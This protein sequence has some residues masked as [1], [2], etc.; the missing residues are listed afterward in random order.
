MPRI[1]NQ[2]PTPS[3]QGLPPQSN[4]TPSER[5][6]QEIAA[7]C[8][9]PEP[10]QS[11]TS[12][13]PSAVVGGI[14]PPSP[15]VLPE[16]E[17]I[18]QLAN[19]RNA[20]PPELRRNYQTAVDKILQAYRTN[21]TELYLSNLKLET[22]PSVIGQLTNLTTLYL[23]NNGLPF[24]P[25]EIGQLT[26]LTYL[27]LSGCYL[28]F[29]PPEIAQL[30]NLSELQLYSNNLTSI[31]EEIGRF[32]N[33][34]ELCLSCNQFPNI[35][36]C[37]YS[38]PHE[39][40][41][42]LRENPHIPTDALAAMITRINQPGYSGPTD[43]PIDRA[44]V[45]ALEHPKLP[46]DELLKHWFSLAEIT[47]D[48]SFE[49]LAKE[50]Q[51]N[52]SLHTFLHRLPEAEDYKNSNRQAFA[53]RVC[54]VLQKM[55]TDPV[56]KDKVIDLMADGLRHCGDRISAAWNSVEA[57][58]RLYDL[59]N[60]PATLDVASVLLGLYR[61][62]VLDQLAATHSRGIDD[63][64][65]CLMLQIALKDYLHLPI[66]THHLRFGR[67][68]GLTREKIQAIAEQ[69]RSS[70]SSVEGL[71]SALQFFPEWSDH[72]KSTATWKEEEAKWEE[73][74]ETTGA[75]TSLDLNLTEANK[76]VEALNEHLEASG[77]STRLQPYTEKYTNIDRMTNG[78]LLL[79]AKEEAFKNFIAK[80]SA[81]WLNA[82][83]EELLH[84]I[85]P[86]GAPI[87]FNVL[88]QE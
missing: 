42:D 30:T 27:N 68:S 33:L 63:V 55:R 36:E 78:K 6:V 17:I 57:L 25:S 21:S 58:S 85:N 65:M 8:L 56:F 28:T 44:Y 51:N 46:L 37:I 32:T 2:S 61:M 49:A 67:L 47:L 35:P 74:M 39:C 18:Q 77:I 1:N 23:S 81:S 87:H 76:A 84:R 5:Q 14:A 82:H 52:I 7:H 13:M 80:E 60:S 69:V 10:R 73:W 50:F 16:S 86:P 71:S 40:M 26:N 75:D 54:H 70:T 45:Y 88:P 9:S 29:L 15:Q 79:Q 72:L 34:T 48:T 31:P 59:G 41:I 3:T 38:L 20:A 53:K 19:W 4:I 83:H 43:I 22:L 12:S 24:L 64:S 11:A 62:Q 66:D